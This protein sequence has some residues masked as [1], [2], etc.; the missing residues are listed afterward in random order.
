MAL[1]QYSLKKGIKKFGEARVQEVIS[2]QQHDGIQR[3]AK[4]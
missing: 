3:Q 2:E 1:T 4:L